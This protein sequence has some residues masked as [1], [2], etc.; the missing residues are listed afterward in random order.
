MKKHFKLGCYALYIL[1]FFFVSHRQLPTHDPVEILLEDPR[2]VV[3]KSKTKF[4]FVQTPKY[5]HT[6]HKK[7]SLNIRRPKSYA[8]LAPSA[9][10]VRAVYFVNTKIH[11]HFDQWM[12]HQ[13][14]VFPK[15]NEL[16]VVATSNNCDNNT[17]L[18]NAFSRVKSRREEDIIELECHEDKEETFEY[19]GIHKVWELGQT[20]FAA[21][22]IGIYFHSKGL[23]HATSYKDWTIKMRGDETL[24][25]RVFTPMNKVLEA[26]A[27]F[28]D[29][30][31]AG[32]LCGSDSRVWLNFMYLR[33][34]Y[35]HHLDKPIVTD[36]RHYY[37]DWS[38][39]WNWN[40]SSTASSTEEPPMDSYPKE[41]ILRYHRC[42]TLDVDFYKKYSHFPNIGVP[43]DPWDFLP[44]EAK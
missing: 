7:S 24:M 44:S 14:T 10:T 38:G 12:D 4:N 2:I 35:V 23:T 5:K 34:S 1:V 37:E 31:K 18:H 16:Y 6:Y 19:H 3:S 13:L 8:D 21:N 11:D 15:V 25:E 27:L 17:I 9:F 26:F 36:R 42:Y 39:R 20:Y 33:G 43:W 29:V 30:D 40:A 22:D 28:P 41:E 32:A